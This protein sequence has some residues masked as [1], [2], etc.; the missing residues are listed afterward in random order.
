M[1]GKRSESKDTPRCL[2]SGSLLM[3]FPKIQGT[4]E[5]EQIQGILQIMISFLN[6]LTL[7]L[8]IRLPGFSCSS[9]GKESACNAGDPGL[10]PGSRKIPWRKNRLPIPVCMGFPS[11]SDSKESACNMGDLGTI[12]GLGKSPGGAHS[13]SLQYSCL[14]NLHG[15]RS[16][17]GYSPWGC[18]E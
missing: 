1:L 14:E 18:K 15:Q 11:G 3:P 7:R 6:R 12:P 5:G 8:P 17:V 9:A 2:S 4:L 13:N 10:I 16:L